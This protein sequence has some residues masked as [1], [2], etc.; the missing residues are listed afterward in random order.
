MKMVCIVGR[1]PTRTETFIAR[2][3]EALQRAGVTLILCALAEGENVSAPALPS[4]RY[5]GSRV[6][7]GIAFA[8]AYVRDTP[9]ARR[10]WRAARAVAPDAARA[11]LRAAT[12]LR[13][14]RDP[15]LQSA[16]LVH[17]H[18]LHAPCEVG[19]S[20]AAAL[21]VP[22]TAS[23]HAWDIHVPPAS[24]TRR[25]LA[26]LA[27]VFVC[28]EQGL[29]AL[30]RMSPDAAGRLELLRH[31]L[32]PDAMRTPGAAGRDIVAIGRLVPKK[33]FDLLVTA[34]ARLRDAG[35]D[36]DCH[37]LGDGPEAA[38]L[39]AA[40][41][42]AGVQDRMRLAGA[43]APD[44][45]PAWLDRARVLV[46]PSRVGADG[47]RD[48][49][50]N[51]VLEAMARGVPVVVSDASAAPEVV[52]HEMDGLIVPTEDA[53]ALAAALERLLA[54]DTLHDRLARAAHARAQSFS[55]DAA[56]QRMVASLRTVIEEGP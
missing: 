50:P 43:V 53:A 33:G 2:E 1:H 31:G 42:A 23:A 47:D 37:I 11:W 38:R 15:A 4:V 21:G 49:V 56:A 46:A 16:D 14:A 35:H 27:R 52:S 54:D 18:F 41:E 34:C 30:K 48:G 44:E 45:V 22:C 20:L 40:I 9:R 12:A 29:D 5:A 25:R 51:V 55:A 39:A 24:A 32:A 13:W 10:A 28:T 36:V 3:C 7:R 19:V 8:W 6:A 17:A 26:R